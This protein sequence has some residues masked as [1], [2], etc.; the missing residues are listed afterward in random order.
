MDKRAGAGAPPPPPPFAVVLAPPLIV[1]H[2]DVGDVTTEEE[3]NIAS[4]QAT[5]CKIRSDEQAKSS[6][7]GKKRTKLEYMGVQLPEDVDARRKLR[8][9][10]S[11]KV[12]RKRKQDSLDSV[13]KLVEEYDET[14]TELKTQLIGL[15]NIPGVTEIFDE[16]EKSAAE[17][18]LVTNEEV[19]QPNPDLANGDG[20]LEGQNVKPEK[21][22]EENVASILMGMKSPD[23]M[24]QPAFDSNGKRIRRPRT[25]APVINGE[26]LPTA[27]DEKTRKLRRLMRNRTHA[28]R[29]R[30]R[31][32]KEVEVLNA[33]RM[34]KESQISK[35]RSI[36]ESAKGKSVD[37]S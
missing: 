30:E 37:G 11:A 2:H 4:A 25:V 32:K 31:K 3:C 13:K 6:S 15:G 36:L 29:S 24:P 8:N 22:G 21:P 17:E 5:L 23:E 10:L 33:Q 34:R 1:P 14:I 20:L 35:M 12:H 9:K 19:A 28:R 16:L 27:P 26:A 18:E 7:T